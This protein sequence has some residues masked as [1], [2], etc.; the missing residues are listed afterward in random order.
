GILRLAVAITEAEKRW[1]TLDTISTLYPAARVLSQAKSMATGTQ[2][3][4]GEASAELKV[5]DAETGGL[6]MAAVDRRAGGKTLEKGFSSWA[7][8][9]SAFQYWAERVRYRLC[10]ERGGTGCVAP[11]T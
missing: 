8:V 9:E 6:L 3:F 1:V 11:E 7:D 2:S 10:N 5:T 4:V